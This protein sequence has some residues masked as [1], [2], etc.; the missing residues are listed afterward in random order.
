MK[1]KKEK[2]SQWWS[3]LLV[4]VTKHAMSQITVMNINYIEALQNVNKKYK[5][6]I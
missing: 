4:D 1:N 5:S 6:Q 2:K 3:P